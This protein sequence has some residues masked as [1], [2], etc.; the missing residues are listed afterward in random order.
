MGHILL[1]MKVNL[2]MTES[3]AAAPPKVQ[4]EGCF[5]LAL[6]RQCKDLQE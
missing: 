4:G 3:T 1:R 2:A 6:I 5:S